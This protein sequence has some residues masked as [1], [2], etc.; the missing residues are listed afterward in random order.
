MKILLFLGLIVWCGALLAGE[1]TKPPFLLMGISQEK[2]LR[3][4]LSP[5]ITPRKQS[6]AV[7]A[8]TMRARA[9]SE[10]SLVQKHCAYYEGLTSQQRP[11]LLKPA[12]R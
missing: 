8:H 6:S 5:S 11:T 1:P 7:T 9:Q 3:L 4:L 10:G 2:N 12:S